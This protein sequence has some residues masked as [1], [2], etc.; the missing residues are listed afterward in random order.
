[1][2]LVSPIMVTRQL[3]PVVVSPP[4]SAVTVY[5]V[6]TDPP[7]ATGPAQLIVDCPSAP[8]VA[9][10]SD[11]APGAVLARS[12][13]NDQAEPTEAPSPGDPTRATAACPSE[14]G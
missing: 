7:S 3:G 4:G 9:V 13:S 11:G 14:P 5:E 10:T 2:L 6:T 12:F 8:L 1:M